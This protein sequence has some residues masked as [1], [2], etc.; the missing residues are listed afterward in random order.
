MSVKGLDRIEPTDY[1]S[2]M[3]DDI[4]NRAVRLCF[5][6]DVSNIDCSTWISRNQHY[7]ESPLYLVPIIV[8]R[9]NYGPN[10]DLL[11]HFSLYKT[12][13]KICAIAI[14]TLLFNAEVRDIM[15]T[16]QISETFAQY[17][18]LYFKGV[19]IIAG[20][21]D[22]TMGLSHSALSSKDK[23][24][25]ESMILI[26]IDKYNKI[27]ASGIYIEP[28]LLNELNDSVNAISRAPRELMP[29]I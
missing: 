5:A 13:D 12:A 4:S 26:S 22:N 21:D 25:I 8:S 10:S 17:L 16:S 7:L 9:G 23:E 1:E 11:Y 2:A 3:V 6:Q 27:Q 14:K 18:N 15:Q 29:F 24:L 28:S 20:L 19:C